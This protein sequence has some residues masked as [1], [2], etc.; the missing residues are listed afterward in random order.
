MESILPIALNRECLIVLREVAKA[1]LDNNGRQA[2]PQGSRGKAGDSNL[3][4]IG[5]A[6]PFSACASIA[7]YLSHP[8]GSSIV[9]VKPADNTSN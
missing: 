2:A 4:V 8:A 7:C 9:E 5:R 3:Y 1:Y 6:K